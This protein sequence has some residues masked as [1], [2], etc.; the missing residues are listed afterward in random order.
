MQ[1]ALTWWRRRPQPP[2][3]HDFAISA[4]QDVEPDDDYLVEED[5]PS[6]RV[7]VALQVVKFLQVLLVFLMAALSLAVF[8]L[9]GT[10]LN[11]F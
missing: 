3:R 11:I 4:P 10:L 1:M 2:P 6:F 8:W 5:E 7:T 9:L